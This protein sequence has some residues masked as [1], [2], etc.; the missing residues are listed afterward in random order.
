MVRSVEPS[1]SHKMEGF[2]LH[3]IWLVIRSS[4]G[5]RLV[6]S[7]SDACRLEEYLARPFLLLCLLAAVL[8]MPLAIKGSQMYRSPVGEGSAGS[9]QNAPK[10]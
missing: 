3:V 10:M 8:S 7:R 9:F 1:V 6:V 5:P 2:F 4:R